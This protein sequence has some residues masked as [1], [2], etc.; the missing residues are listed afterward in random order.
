MNKVVISWDES[1]TTGGDN[2]PLTSYK[3]SALP[4]G[5]STYIEIDAALCDEDMTTIIMMLQCS[6]DMSIFTGE[7]FN[8]I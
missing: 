4:K 2:I 6:F 1:A 5:A 8:L 3:F 7:T